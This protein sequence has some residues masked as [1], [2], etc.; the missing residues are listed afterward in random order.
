VT[1]NQCGAIGEALLLCYRYDPPAV[2]E[3]I[4]SELAALP[5]LN[6]DVEDL[7]VEVESS[8]EPVVVPADDGT[9]TERESQVWVPDCRLVVHD[10][11]SGEPIRTY[12]CEVKTGA[13]SL[14]RNQETVMRH[15]AKSNPVL[16]VQF[17][18]QEL[19]T[20]Y[21]ATVTALHRKTTKRVAEA[22]NDMTQQTPSLS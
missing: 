4:R 15:H 19:P 13:S 18:L 17:D 2:T 1:A 8:V 6:T 12:V 9:E 21:A 10:G 3:Y 20:R 11:R 16:L 14:A 22:A 5:T 7:V